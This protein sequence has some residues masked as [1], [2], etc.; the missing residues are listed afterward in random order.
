[1][2]SLDGS[3]VART[4]RIQ[5]TKS[6]LELLEAPPGPSMADSDAASSCWSLARFVQCRWKGTV[7]ERVAAVGRRVGQERRGWDEK[8]EK[9][10]EKGAWKLTINCSGSDRRVLAG[11]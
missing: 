6:L 4:K 11:T 8:S 5:L 9:S 1:M 3:R 2:V 7:V 10:V